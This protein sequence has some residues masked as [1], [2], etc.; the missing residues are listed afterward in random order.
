MSS[1]QSS[2]SKIR[3]EGSRDQPAQQLVPLLVSELALADPKSLPL[4]GL[5]VPFLGKEQLAQAS[6]HMA[7]SCLMVMAIRSRNPCLHM[8]GSSF[9]LASSQQ[10]FQLAC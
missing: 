1:K 9:H 8:T 10:R 4:R 3:G 7:L 5:L 2:H 6:S